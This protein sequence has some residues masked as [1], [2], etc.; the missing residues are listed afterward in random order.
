MKQTYYAN[1]LLPILFTFIVMAFM[2]CEYD[3]GWDISPD[4]EL[5]YISNTIHG[6]QYEYYLLNEKGE[7]SVVF[8]EG[9]NIRFNIRITNRN[10]DSGQILE[11]YEIYDND[12]GIFNVYSSEGELIG[13]PNRVVELALKMPWF[14]PG[15]SYGMEEIW[16]DSFDAPVGDL[17]PGDYYTMFTKAFDFTGHPS[18][19][20][21]DRSYNTDNITFRIN[22]RVR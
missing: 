8:Y 12:S 21:T 22:F 10:K 11:D 14:F 3:T 16:P 17:P 5:P 2:G 4:S 20:E 15:N 13:K 6:I 18:R 9:E 1:K 19:A 7:K